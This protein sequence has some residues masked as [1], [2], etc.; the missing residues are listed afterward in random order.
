MHDH[1]GASY[2]KTHS[3]TTAAHGYTVCP[4][5]FLLLEMTL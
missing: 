4:R 3:T 1:K 5:K 2:G